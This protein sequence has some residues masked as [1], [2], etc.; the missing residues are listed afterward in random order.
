MNSH[1]R[2][3]MARIIDKRAAKGLDTNARALR[4]FLEWA[5]KPLHDEQRT[6]LSHKWFLREP[7]DDCANGWSFWL[8]P[9]GMV[10]TVGYAEHW[11]F[12]D[13][14]G[15][16]EQEMERAGWLHVSGNTAYQ[17]FP[18]TE[19][20][21]RVWDNLCERAAQAGQ[22]L[23]LKDMQEE[24]ARAKLHRLG[25]DSKDDRWRAFERAPLSSYDW[26]DDKHW[27]NVRPEA[28]AYAMQA[29]MHF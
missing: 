20:Q 17:Y 29:T 19:R 21:R 24:S 4:I 10:W 23:R 16:R 9:S 8:S 27:Q 7:V 26:A 28:E 22:H 6:V 11:F 1:L 14:T 13:V 18:L 5:H 25:D 3:T 12:G 15:L 2:A